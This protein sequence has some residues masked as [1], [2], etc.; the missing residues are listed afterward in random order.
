[1]GELEKKIQKRNRLSEAQQAILSSIA[2]AGL[3]GVGA[4]APNILR[5]TPKRLIDMIGT[6]DEHSL[7]RSRN[8]LVKRGY[9][10]FSKKAGG[11][12]LTEKGRIH[13]E[14]RG[15]SKDIKWD[16]K[17]RLL[18]FDISE[19]H[20]VGRDSVRRRLAEFG[21]IRLQDSVWVYP[22]PCDEYIAL[23]KTELKL[24]KNLLYLIADEFE[25]EESLLEHFKLSR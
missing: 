15:R 6:S 3:L 5:F 18:I 25:G 20:K 16:R 22:Y 14:S 7:R 8:S 4:I 9:V 21:L 11:Y 24:G 17:W 12:I 13:S 1:M 23:L 19:K 2:F 10:E